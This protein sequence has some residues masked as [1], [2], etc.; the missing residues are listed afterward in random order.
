MRYVL[1]VEL[2]DNDYCEG[3]PQLNANMHWCQALDLLLGYYSHRR[4]GSWSADH[5]RHEKCP[6][7]EVKR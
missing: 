2:N 7:K 5:I 4:N 3:C 1:E 6:L